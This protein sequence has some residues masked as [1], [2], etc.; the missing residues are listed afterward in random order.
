MSKRILLFIIFLL[1]I[2]CFEVPDRLKD[3]CPEGCKSYFYCDE[4]EKKCK[5]KGFFPL[6][7]LELI[8]LFILMI[9]SSLATSC[10]IGGG[11]VY[12]SIILGVEELEPSQAFP[13]SNFLILLCGF[14]TFISFAL[15]KYQ[16]P[17][18]LFIHYDVAT[19]FAPSMLVGAKFGTILNK[20]LPSTLLLILL[21]CLVCFTTRKTYYNILKAKAREAK[22]NEKEKFLENNGEDHE[23][24][25]KNKENHHFS[26]NN[27]MT[28]SIIIHEAFANEDKIEFSKFSSFKDNVSYKTEL[29]D[30]EK[31]KILNEDDYPLNWERINYILFL[32]FV[33]IIDQLIEG[34]SRVPSFLGIK[35]CSFFYWLTFIIFVI[36]CLYFV[37]VSINKVYVHIQTKKKVFPEFKS[38]IIDKIEKNTIFVVSIAIIAGIVSSSLGLGGG[39]ITNPLFASLGMEPKQSSTTSNFLIIVTAIASSFIFILSGQLEIG[40]SICLG[41]FC[42]G[43][44]LIGSF[45][46]LKYINRTGKS[47]I[48]LVIMEYFLVISFFITIYKLFT[49]DLKGYT[50]FESLFVLN[51]FC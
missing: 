8:E 47:S 41:I 14:V 15:D 5:F 7:P 10:G 6:Y 37:K 13:I 21:C 19:I 35:R 50:F 33:V 31:Q 30:D 11:I 44:A 16:H 3:I 46:I 48:L 29:N 1:T 23:K 32:E 17:K 26:N 45:Y 34:S 18:S 42:T 49:F 27:K 12:S 2:K 22:L 39:M 24:N 25:D 4:K 36:I 43:A 28:D 40:Y 38:E 51:R 20:I 9:S